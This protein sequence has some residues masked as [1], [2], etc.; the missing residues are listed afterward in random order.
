MG[1]SQG[2]TGLSDSG[3]RRRHRRHGTDTV[4]CEMGEVVELSRSGM[5]LITKGKP[6]LRVQQLVTVTLRF[7][8]RLVKVQAQARWIKRSGLRKHVLG[9]AFVNVSDQ[10]ANALESVARYGFVC[11]QPNDSNA[12]QTGP[13]K[14]P[15]KK[16]AKVTIDLPDYYK[17]LELDRD[18]TVDELRS[19][20]RRLA[21]TYHPDTNK[22]P[23]AMSRF[24]EIK[25]AYEVLSD[26]DQ[27]KSYDAQAA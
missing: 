16:P 13:K 9:L 3:E 27:R 5:R 17:L 23:D 25:R 19:A 4:T 7:D 22:S 14:E 18:A 2:K 12:D 26:P 21:H 10:I 6:P 1:A 15:P 11:V 24:I 8:G 20:Y